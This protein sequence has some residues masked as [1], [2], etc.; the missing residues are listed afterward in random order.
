GG[1]K[2]NP[3]HGGPADSDTT[4]RI[5]DLANELLAGRNAAVARSERVASAEFDFLGSYVADLDAAIDL[6]A[7]RRAG[8]RIGADP[9][10]GASVA[11]WAAVRDRYG[12]DITVLGPGVDPRWAFMT[13][14]WDGRIR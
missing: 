5:A 11:Y 2:Y 9:L 10:G 3:P 4:R 6:D 1:I 7:I 12:L 8:V 13:L 14:D